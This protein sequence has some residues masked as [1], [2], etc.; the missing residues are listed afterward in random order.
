MSIPIGCFNRNVIALIGPTHITLRDFL[1]YLRTH[2]DDGTCDLSFRVCC[3]AYVIKITNRK[4]THQLV[5]C[6]RLSQNVGIGFVSFGMVWLCFGILLS[7]RIKSTSSCFK[8]QQQK[9]L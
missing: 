2:R 7:K 5:H 3:A 4:P 9:E 6:D 1:F 8:Q